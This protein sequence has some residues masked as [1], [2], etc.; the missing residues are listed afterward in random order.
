[1][2]YEI[3]QVAL[4]E[5]PRYTAVLDHINKRA[6][7]NNLPKVTYTTGESFIVREPRFPPNH[8]WYSSKDLV[9]RNYINLFFSLDEVKISGYRPLA[10]LEYSLGKPLS[11]IWPGEEYEVE[12]WDCRDCEHCGIRIKRN[13]IF[14]LE[15]E[16]AGITHIGSTCVKD[17]LGYDPSSMLAQLDYIKKF[18]EI[19]E[20][21]EDKPKGK[22]NTNLDLGQVL[23]YTAAVVRVYGYT[24]KGH[25]EETGVSPTAERVAQLF[26]DR[27]D[28]P[29]VKIT[30]KDRAM[31]TAALEAAKAIT[32]TS[33]SYRANINTIAILGYLNHK[34]LGFAVSII[35]FYQLELERAAKEVER[36]ANLP[37]SNYLGTVGEVL[38]IQA[39]LDSVKTIDG[40]YGVTYLVKFT[41]ST[42]D[43]VSW[44]ASNCP[45]F[46][47]GVELQL[48]GRVKAH[49]EYK[50]LKETMV[51]RCKLTTV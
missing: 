24:S 27:K 25:A 43:K 49:N 7:K 29:K 47:D 2:G 41:A 4:S 9:D 35:R 13:R 21:D 38:R 16:E 46:D 18:H 36:L 1:M 51:T 19:G 17:F 30:A 12:D 32:D 5:L 15:H 45:N 28:N 20:E 6:E 40:N 33:N 10:T 23:A 39:T 3:K 31:A 26:Y 8:F 48:K 44:F 14:V 50:G 42:G 37:D 22:K 11:Y 34:S